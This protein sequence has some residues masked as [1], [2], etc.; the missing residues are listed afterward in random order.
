MENVN[1]IRITQKF[2]YGPVKDAS[3]RV[4]VEKTKFMNVTKLK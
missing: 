3:P 4:N 1:I 2:T